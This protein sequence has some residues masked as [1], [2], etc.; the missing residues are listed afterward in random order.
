MASPSYYRFVFFS[1]LHSRWDQLACLRV[2]LQTRQA[3]SI[4]LDSVWVGGDLLDVHHARELSVRQ[5]AHLSAK[6]RG[7]DDPQD[8][9]DYQRVLAA[10][11]DLGLPVWVVPGNHD[12]WC[13]FDPDHGVWT[14][15]PAQLAHGRVI[16]LAK[17][18]FM[19]ALGGS[20][21]VVYRTRPD[22]V[23]W[24]G[25]P[26]DETSLQRDLETVQRQLSPIQGSVVWFTHM[27]PMGSATCIVNRDPN[28]ASSQDEEF[29]SSALT[30]ALSSQP[31]THPAILNIHGHVHSAHNGPVGLGQTRVVNPGALRDGRF[32]EV[33]LS[34][35]DATQSAWSLYSS[36]F[37]TL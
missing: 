36:Q 12:P 18:L 10:V 26:Y 3:S 13:A 29:G 33:V 21:D 5:E 23:V 30:A 32:V 8:V 11:S 16:P 2:W 4:P 31:V 9:A 1:D 6:N 37:H 22:T 14:T 28:K 35:P 27:G 25:F 20:T 24:E 17:G 15:G 7:T 34:G 19:A